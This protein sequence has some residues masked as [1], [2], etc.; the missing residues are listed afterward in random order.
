MSSPNRRLFPVDSTRFAG[1]SDRRLT[2]RRL[3][4]LVVGIRPDMTTLR[5]RS[6]PWF[7]LA[8]AIC[9]VGFVIGSAV[10]LAVA[11]LVMLAACIRYVGLSVQDDPVRS[12]IVARRSAI[13]GAMVYDGMAGRRRRVRER[14]KLEDL[15]E[16]P[17]PGSGAG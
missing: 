6:A 13:V 1:D 10:L 8:A 12:R 4:A 3:A 15:G 17:G 14:R 7:L 9:V 16:R 5:T 11:L 2:V